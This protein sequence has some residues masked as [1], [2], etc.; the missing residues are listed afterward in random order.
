M[1]LP[2]NKRDTIAILGALSLFCSILEFLVPK[3]IP[4]IRI[5]FANFPIL[6]SLLLLSPKDT[7]I[8]I[9][10][11]SLGSS[12]VTG[13]LFS[14]I[15]LYSI[16]G[17]LASGLIM[18]MFYHFL[19]LKVSMVGICVI[20]ALSSNLTQIFIAKLFLGSG[21]KYIGI[22]ILISGL[23]SGILLGLFT[24]RFISQSRWVRSK[25]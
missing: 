13:T 4:F 12:I 7:L 5:G 15:F 2:I 19:R 14:W 25:L 6:L 10:I 22:P 8:L 21:A 11:K 18:L 9:F 1:S 23:V 17:S 24:N 3:P 20:G 16:T